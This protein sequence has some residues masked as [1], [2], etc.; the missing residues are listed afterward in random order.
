MRAM[1]G[2]TFRIIDEVLNRRL[3]IAARYV[4]VSKIAAP[5]LNYEFSRGYREYIGEIT[6]CA[7]SLRVNNDVKQ[8]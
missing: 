4:N 1:R 5:A 8:I 3:C 2:V 7:N 6:G